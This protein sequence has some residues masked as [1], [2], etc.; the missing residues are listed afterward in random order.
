MGVLEGLVRAL[1]A[2]VSCGCGQ[3]LGPA[4]SLPPRRSFLSPH[5]CKDEIAQPRR[6]GEACQVLPPL[7]HYLFSSWTLLEMESH[8]SCL[9]CGGQG[10]VALAT[11]SSLSGGVWSFGEAE[12]WI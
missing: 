9:L 6:Q 4:P 8:A 2:V 5:P 10:S 12:Q 11:G 1:Q 3:T 7:P